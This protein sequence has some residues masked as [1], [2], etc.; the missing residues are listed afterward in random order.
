MI[1]RFDL[2][3]AFEKGGESHFDFS[4]FGFQC[5][6]VVYLCVECLDGFA[7][8]MDHADSGNN[9]MVMSCACFVGGSWSFYLTP[10]PLLAI[11]SSL[12]QVRRYY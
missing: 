6:E 12:Y 10:A 3:Q 1:V 2:F 9:E 7:E 11:R 5:F 8:D 4:I